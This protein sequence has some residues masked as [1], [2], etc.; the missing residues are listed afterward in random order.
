M[1]AA[2]FFERDGVLN[3][4]RVERQN[5][6]TPLTLDEFKVKEEAIEPIRALKAAGFLLLATSNQPGLSRGYQSRRELDLMHGILRKRFDLDDVL[7]CAH[8]EMDRCTCR[9]PSP[10]LLSEAAFKWHLDMDRCFMISDKWQDAQAAHNAG[11]TSLLIKSPW[12]GSGHRDFILP[13]IEAVVHKILQTRLAHASPR[14]AAP[15]RL[16]T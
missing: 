12:N 1:K 11:C 13:N 16:R 6:A 8:D 4:T 3:H 15:E 7:V 10:G 14:A 2:V 5:Q 9:K